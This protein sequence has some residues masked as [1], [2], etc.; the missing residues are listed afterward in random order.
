MRR[1]GR[2]GVRRAHQVHVIPHQRAEFLGAGAGEQGQHDVGAHPGVLGGGEH[3]LGLGQGER[4]RRTAGLSCRD[5]AE[6]D[7]GALHPQ[8]FNYSAEVR[9][10]LPRHSVSVVGI[11]VNS[12]GHVLVIRRRDNGHWQ[13]P[14]DVLELSEPFEQGVRRE[15]LEEA[16]AQV[17]V[18]RL[19]G[20]YK[21]IA[22]PQ[23][24]THD[25]TNIL[26]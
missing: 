4:L 18:E 9:A 13:P 11:V 26:T 22:V 2:V 5:R 17:H 8:S 10:A 6:R 15:V 12:D 23:I 3:G 7:H 25:G 16:S 1:N 19:S 14:G 24:R 20:L 21:N